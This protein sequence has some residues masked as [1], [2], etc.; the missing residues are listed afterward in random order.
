MASIQGARLAPGVIVGAAIAIAALLLAIMPT[1]ADA[2]TANG[3]FER[4]STFEVQDNEGSEVAEIVAATDDGNTLIYT[5]SAAGALGFV[6]ISDPSTPTA[7]G[8]VKLGLDSD[9]V[10]IDGEDLQILRE[11]TGSSA[12]DTSPS[13]VSNTGVSPGAR[14]ARAIMKAPER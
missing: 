1:V 4:I 8:L 3:G 2:A 14:R 11:P 12:A 10:E 5:D 7:A 13:S 6:D 9:L